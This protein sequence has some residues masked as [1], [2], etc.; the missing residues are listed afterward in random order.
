MSRIRFF[1][2]VLA[3][4]LA[5]ASVLTAAAQATA[6]IH[7]PFSS[8]AVCSPMSIIVREEQLPA[9]QLNPLPPLED[10]DILLTDCAHS[11]GWRHGHAA[12]VVDAAAG[13]TLEA[14][15]CF[16]PSTLQSAQRWRRYPTFTVLRLRDADP[17]TRREVARYALD[18]LLGV[19]YSLV[20]GL[21]G[22]KA[23]AEP[24]ASQCAYLVWYAYH[25]FGY[26]LD[27]DSGRLVTVQDLMD[28]PLLET[29]QQVGKPASSP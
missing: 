5:L 7:L 11:F 26:D 9:D 18:N 13:Q 24:G 17:Q 29:V 23:P 1:A 22:E 2:A 10:G 21:F 4:T 19:D 20:S 14:I 6:H 12:L 15:T 25:R 8:P 28:S 16:T 27:G 3:L